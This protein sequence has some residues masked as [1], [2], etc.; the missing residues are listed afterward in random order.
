M[1]GIPAIQ[2]ISRAAVLL[3]VTLVAGPV[4]GADD[5][6][7]P[8]EIG[9]YALTPSIVSNLSGGP[10]YIRCDVQLMTQH[11]QTLPQIELHAAALRHAILMLI[12][13]EDGNQLRSREGKEALRTKALES[14]QGQLKE[15]TGET[16]VSDLFFTNY[17]VK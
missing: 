5:E 11:A 15:L 17:Y 8:V 10:K 12:A 4:T 16:L 2:L 1:K 13:G 3:A 6:Q 7:P 9:Y 14:V